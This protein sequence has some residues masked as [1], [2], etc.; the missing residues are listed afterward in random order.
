[1]LMTLQKVCPSPSASQ[2]KLENLKNE[3]LHSFDIKQ[4]D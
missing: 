3:I 4:N 1:M 2:T